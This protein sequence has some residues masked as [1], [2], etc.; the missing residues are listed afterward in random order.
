[1]EKRLVDIHVLCGQTHLIEELLKTQPE[2]L[3]NQHDPM[4]HDDE[5]L[6]WWLI[7]PFLAQKLRQQGE[8]VISEFGNHW[9]GR[10]QSGQAICMDAV[11][12][13][14]CKRLA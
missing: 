1:M 14:I 4:N 5:I 9:W 11:I 3:T 6:E 2:L 13:D 8:T 10:T 12:K 7:T